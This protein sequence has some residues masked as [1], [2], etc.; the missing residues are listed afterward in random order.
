MQRPSVKRP[1]FAVVLNPASQPDA[2]VEIQ[3]DH[4]QLGEPEEMGQA[5]FALHFH[6]AQMLAE[7][8]KAENAQTAYA[9][10]QEGYLREFQSAFAPL[11]N[12]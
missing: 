5:L 4:N 10:L 9:R 7:T 12:S 6:V 8:G 11:L 1:V 3:I 2:S